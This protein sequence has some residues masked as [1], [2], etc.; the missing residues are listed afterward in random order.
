[1]KDDIKAG[2]AFIDA[3]DQTERTAFLGLFAGARFPWTI[4]DDGRGPFIG[5]AECEWV[6]DWR[7]FYAVRLPAAGLFLWEEGETGPALG[8]VK[9]PNGEMHNWTRIDCCPT[10][11]GWKVREAWWDRFNGRADADTSGA[12]DRTRDEPNPT[13]T[14]Q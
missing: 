2:L 7:D 13:G 14:P 1:M 11:L 10:Q 8:M 12:N 4:Y 9:K 3:L 5:K 6:E